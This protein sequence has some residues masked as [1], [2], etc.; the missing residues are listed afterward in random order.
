MG[1]QFEAPGPRTQPSLP[2][3]GAPTAPR[4]IPLVRHVVP[5]PVIHMQQRTPM[6]A[7]P[8]MGMAGIGVPGAPGMQMGMRPQGGMAQGRPTMGIDMGG[9]PVKKARPA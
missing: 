2:Q 7:I 9:P 4:V 6:G 3:P 8:R 1:N 5:Q